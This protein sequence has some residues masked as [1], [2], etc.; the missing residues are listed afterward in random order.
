MNEVK[1]VGGI[2]RAVFEIIKTGQIFFC[3]MKNE[4]MGRIVHPFH[5]LRATADDGSPVSPGQ[6]GG[7]EAGDFNVLL[8]GEAVRNGDGICRDEGRM[9]IS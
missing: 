5:Q 6:R 3:M 8:F 1:Q 7:K 9:V 4:I 2:E